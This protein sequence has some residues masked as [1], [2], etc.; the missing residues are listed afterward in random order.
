ME[1]VLAQVVTPNASLIG[2][3]SGILAGLVHVYVL[4]GVVPGS[5]GRG[6]GAPRWLSRRLSALRNWRLPFHGVSPTPP[7]G[8]CL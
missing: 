4:Q 1:L 7:S 3:L 6:Q 8:G 2:H 5:R